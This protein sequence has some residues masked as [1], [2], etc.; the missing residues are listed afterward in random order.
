MGISIGIAVASL[1]IGSL[2]T[3]ILS[4][5]YYHKS[6]GDIA[7]LVKRLASKEEPESIF[8]TGDVENAK[9]PVPMPRM[10]AQGV[11][12]GPEGAAAQLLLE[13]LDAFD[14]NKIYWHEFTIAAR[15]MQLAGK[16]ATESVGRVF[17]A[18][19]QGAMTT[20]PE[21]HKILAETRRAEMLK[22]RQSL[23]KD[24]SR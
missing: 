8:A 14:K 12:P 22:L 4:K 24:S 2:V 19:S 5:H 7:R 23:Q 6:S 16:M 20:T 18:A 11:R 15:A 21:Y 13:L 10:L 9:E 17:S 3:I 1:I